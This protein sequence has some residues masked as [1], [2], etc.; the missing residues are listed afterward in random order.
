MF[1]VK[2]KVVPF[3]AMVTVIVPSL[4][5]EVPLGTG[6]TLSSTELGTSCTQVKLSGYV[7]GLTEAPT[8]LNNGAE[9]SV[10]EK[11][12]VATN[13]DATDVMASVAFLAEKFILPSLELQRLSR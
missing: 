13:T 10:L 7:V 12:V 8:G 1:D 3:E 5:V 9:K 6:S 2:S 11:S 4:K